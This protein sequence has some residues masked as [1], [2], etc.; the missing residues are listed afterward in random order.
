M[1]AMPA[2]LTPAKPMP[3]LAGKTDKVAA[4]ATPDHG[5]VWP[6]P[7]ASLPAPNGAI[8]APTSPAPQAPAVSET[9]ADALPAAAPLKGPIPLPRRRPAL[10]AMVQTAAVTTAVPLPRARPAGAPAPTPDTMNDAGPSNYDA[11][12]GSGHY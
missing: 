10:Y 12:M 11:G 3:G 1:A 5:I 8:P 6:D 4:T 9:D 7:S 2:P